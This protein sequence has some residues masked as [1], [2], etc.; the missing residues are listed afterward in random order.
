[1][2]TR[3]TTYCTRRR[4]SRA[5]ARPQVNASAIRTEVTPMSRRLDPSWTVLVSCQTVEADRCVDVFS[6]PDG[7]FGFEEFRRDPEDLGAWTP[8]EYY[9]RREYPTVDAARTAAREAVPWLAGIL[10]FRRD[11]GAV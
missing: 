10:A 3:L 4:G 7:T 9:S 6:R 1:M 2:A 5:A 11:W 8:A